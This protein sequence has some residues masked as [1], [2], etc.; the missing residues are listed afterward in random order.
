MEVRPAHAYAP[1][2]TALL[3]GGAAACAPAQ[4]EIPASL[5]GASGLAV[6]GRQGLRITERLRFGTYEAVAIERSWTGGRDVRILGYERERRDQRFAFTLAVGGDEVW[7]VDCKATLRTRGFETRG[8][9]IDPED[10]SSLDCRMRGSDDPDARFRMLV[11]EENER[12][13]KGTLAND[14]RRIDVLGTNRIQGGVVPVASASGYELRE[15]GTTLAA[16]EVI[17]DGRVWIGTPRDQA[18]LAAA[19]ASLLLLEDLRATLTEE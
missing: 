3:W 1:V 14:D 18:L 16:V 10:R 7:D 15:D 8:V 17:N 11:E 9:E 5:A 13:M 12:P 6:E 2:L 4:M 19:A